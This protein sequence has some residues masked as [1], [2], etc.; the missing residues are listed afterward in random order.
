MLTAYHHSASTLNLLRAF[1]QGG[2]ADLHQVSRWNM[3]FVES[4]TH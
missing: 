2:L 4:R 1:A 3:G